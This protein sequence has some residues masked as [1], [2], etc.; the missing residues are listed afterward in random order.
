MDRH[1]VQTNLLANGVLVLSLGVTYL[2]ILARI[3]VRATARAP[4][5]DRVDGIVVP[6][7]SLVA[8]EPSA[9]FRRRLD[10]AARIA[11]DNTAAPLWLLGGRMP[12]QPHSEAAAGKA[13]LIACGI[14]AER[15]GVEEHSRNT[16]ENFQQ[17]AR[18]LP[19]AA[20]T[21]LVLVTS[22]YHLRRSETIARNLGLA[23]RAYP[24]EDALVPSLRLP[25]LLAWEAYLLH[26]YHV[27]TLFARLTGNHAML[28]RVRGTPLTPG[29]PQ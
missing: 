6:G 15:I 2:A 5:L 11:R 29:D 26:W 24:A 22:R 25:W 13:Y 7:H 18:R 17:A 4:R 3:L 19:A 10:C 20:G 1:A 21:Q 28:H 8:G 14:A 16:L 12:E 23:I 9:D 27:G